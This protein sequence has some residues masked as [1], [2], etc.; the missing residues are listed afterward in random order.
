MEDKLKPFLT[1]FPTENTVFFL[2]RQFSIEPHRVGKAFFFY[3]HQCYVFFI[4][5]YLSFATYFFF[6]HL[7]LLV[8][9]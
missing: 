7:F 6:S 4:N 8:G 2:S 1:Y 5:F 9:G 3:I